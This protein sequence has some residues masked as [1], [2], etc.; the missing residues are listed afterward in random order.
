MK[1]I[2]KLRELLAYSSPGP[3]HNNEQRIG[4]PHPPF[5]IAELDRSSVQCDNNA[6][7]VVAMR[8]AF[9][10]LLDV[11]E[12]ADAYRVTGGWDEKKWLNEAITKLDEVKL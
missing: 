6:A 9:Q 7:L 5:D 3:W 1:T 2:E 10:A 11:V 4:C 12:A 8:N